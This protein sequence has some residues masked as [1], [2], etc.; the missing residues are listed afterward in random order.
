MLQNRQILIS[1]EITQKAKCMH[2]EC[3]NNVGQN[4]IYL[5]WQQG[6]VGE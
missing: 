1:K 5:T 3:M 2:V 6:K 4:E